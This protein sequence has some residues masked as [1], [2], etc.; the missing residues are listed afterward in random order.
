[1]ELQPVK[2]PG[3]PVVAETLTVRKKESAPRK[4]T[5]ALPADE[6]YDSLAKSA[7]VAR[8]DHMQ[9]EYTRNSNDIKLQTSNRK[10]E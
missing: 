5:G 3:E 8:K 9:S 7:E 1:M 6:L 10:A 4:E 2:S